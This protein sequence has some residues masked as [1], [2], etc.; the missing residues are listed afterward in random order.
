MPVDFEKLSAPVT[1]LE[2][3]AERPDIVATELRQRPVRRST[4]TT[5]RGGS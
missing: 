1:R 4:Q 2:F 5:Y 3:R